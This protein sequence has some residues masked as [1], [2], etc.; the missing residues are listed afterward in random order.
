M[1]NMGL[2]G[3]STHGGPHHGFL[4]LGLTAAALMG[5]MLLSLL[6]YG[7]GWVLNCQQLWR[8]YRN[9][10]LMRPPPIVTPA[11]V[12]DSAPAPSMAADGE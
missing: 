2:I 1:S 12:S 10:E 8:D 7:C 6:W 4:P 11:E 3:H 9:A 5:F